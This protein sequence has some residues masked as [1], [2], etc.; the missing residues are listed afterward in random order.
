MQDQGKMDN[1]VISE[2]ESQLLKE[3]DRRQELEEQVAAVEDA[4]TVSFLLPSSFLLTST[5]CPA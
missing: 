5:A 2:L 3:K 1:F 4:W